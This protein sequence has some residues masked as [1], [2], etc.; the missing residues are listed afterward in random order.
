MSIP[1]R[2]RRCS[3]PPGQKLSEEHYRRFHWNSESVA[4]MDPNPPVW[5]IL[6]HALPS[7]PL[8]LPLLDQSR[9]PICRLRR[10]QQQ[11]PN[12]VEEQLI[13]NRHQ[14]QDPVP[15]QLHQCLTGGH[16]PMPLGQSLLRL[17]ACNIPRVS[18]QA[19]VPSNRDHRL[20]RQHEDHRKVVSNG[21]VRGI[22]TRP[23]GRIR[24]HRLSEVP[25]MRKSGDC[26]SVKSS[27]GSHRRHRLLKMRATRN[28][29]LVK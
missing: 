16:R 25:L 22:P 13:R 5:W 9:R 21:F 12:L 14:Q 28:S 11:W 7:H 2:A 24:S 26:L 6:S 4:M 19:H 15:R 17:L 3:L 20:L 18:Q 1:R 8:A 23:L 10:L 29:R 27:N